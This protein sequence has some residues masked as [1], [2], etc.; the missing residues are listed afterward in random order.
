MKP[1]VI[2]PLLSNKLIPKGETVYSKAT[3]FR[4]STGVVA[5]LLS[6]TAGSITVTQQCSLDY[7][8]DNPNA[9]HWYDP[10]NENGSGI[11]VVGVALPITPGRYSTYAP[12]L[13][14]AIRFKVVEQNVDDSVVS[15]TL[16]RQEEY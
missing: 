7:N 11:G 4:E 14:A 2:L 15:L 16:V 10:V 5:V 3:S 12:I 8:E 6:S 1:L 9:A 13:A